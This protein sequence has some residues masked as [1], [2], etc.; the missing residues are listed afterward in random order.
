MR[1]DKLTLKA[2]E[3]LQGSQELARRL[4]NPQIEPAHMLRTLLAQEEGLIR[5]LLNKL[6]VDPQRLIQGVD[7]LLTSLP[8]VS[9]DA[10]VY[11]SPGLN[12]VLD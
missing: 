11:L 7:D 12:K 6:E 9:G 1:F 3:A 2:Q 10:Q 4:Q 5:P 8:R